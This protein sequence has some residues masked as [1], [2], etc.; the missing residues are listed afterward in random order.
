M[1]NYPLYRGRLIDHI[2]LVTNNFEAS[3]AFYISVLA[4]LEIPVVITDENYMWADELVISSVKSSESAG[5]PTGRHHLAF[6][7]MD[8]EMV[9]TFYHVALAHGGS[10]NGVPGERTYHPGY[11]AAF[12]LDPDGNNIEVVYHGEGDRSA[13]SVEVNFSL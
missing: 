8:Y 3:K 10:D 4:V 1:E 6:Q 13:R 2:Q 5:V 7:A 11:Y 12:V 9:D